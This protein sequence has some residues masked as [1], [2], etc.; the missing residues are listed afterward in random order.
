MTVMA[1]GDVFRALLWLAIVTGMAGRS[2]AQ[3]EDQPGDELLAE[4]NPPSVAE[5]IAQLQPI[6]TLDEFL[7]S[8]APS[9]LPTL[10]EELEELAQ[11]LKN[12]GNGLYR[13]GELEQARGVTQELLDLLVDE[14]GQQHWRSR[15]Q[16]ARLRV[17][18]DLAEATTEL[19]SEVLEA[20]RLFGSFDSL[21]Q[22]GEDHEALHAARHYLSAARTCFGADSPEV[23]EALN[24]LGVIITRA[25]RFAESDTCFR[26][27][28]AIWHAQLGGEHPNTATAVFNLGISQY[29]L[30]EWE[31]AGQLFLKAAAMRRSI[32]GDRHEAVWHALDQVADVLQG[33]GKYDLADPLAQQCVDRVRELLGEE[34]LEVAFRLQRLAGGKR[35]LGQFQVAK[36]LYREAISIAESHLDPEHPRL[37]EIR[38][39]FAVVLSDVGEYEEA[40]ELLYRSRS[41]WEKLHGRNHPQIA[42]SFQAEAVI[43]FST[44]DL[45]GAEALTRAAL[46]IRRK[47]GPD[48]HPFLLTILNNLANIM[49]ERGDLAEAEVLHREVLR[50]YQRKFGREHPNTVLGLSGLA[51]VLLTKG[52][53]S[54]A[55]L[56]LNEVVRLRRKLLGGDHPDVAI[57]LHNLSVLYYR[58]GNLQAALRCGE[59]ALELFRRHLGEGHPSTLSAVASISVIQAD[60][61]RPDQA[62]QMLTGLLEGNAAEQP[63]SNRAILHSNLGA[64]L[65][66]HLRPEEAE[67]QYRKAWHVL[68]DLDREASPAA[69]TILGNLASVRLTLEDWEGAIDYLERACSIAETLRTQVLADEL[70]QALYLQR[71]GHA[72]LSSELTHAL[73]RTGRYE[74]AV[75]AAEQG[76][77]R[78]LLDLVARSGEEAAEVTGRDDPNALELQA[79]LARRAAVRSRLV[80]AEVRFARTQ[81]PQ[82][83]ALS[84]QVVLM[85]A[86]RSQ[87]EGLRQEL[88]E[89]ET[90]VRI[91]QRESWP[92][93]DAVDATTI[94]KALK[95]AEGM[96]LYTWSE[97]AVSLLAIPASSEPIDGWIVAAGPRVDALAVEVNQ[98]LQNIR[99]RQD[100]GGR[101]LSRLTELYTQL[102]PEEA[103]GW[104]RDWSRVVVVPDGPLQFLPFQL[105]LSVQTGELALE[106]GP[107]VVLSGSGTLFVHARNTAVQRVADSTDT[108]LRGVI[109]A[110]P[111][112]EPASDSAQERSEGNA[113]AAGHLSALDLLRLYGGRLKPLP[114]SR[115]EAMAIAEMFGQRGWKAQV[116]LGQDASVPKLEAAADSATIVHLAAHGLVGTRTRPTDSSLALAQPV[117]PTVDDIGFLTLDRLLDRWNG[118]LQSC[119]LVVLSAC[120]TQRGVEVGDSLLALPWGFFH[121]GSPSV[122]ASLWQVDDD[123]TALLMRRFYQN[124]L[125]E[126][127]R[128]TLGDESFSGGQPMPKSTALREAQYWLSRRPAEENR[129]DLEGMKE[130]ASARGDQGLILVPTGE[131]NC[132]FSHPRYWA[133]FV[134]LG[135]PSACRLP[136]SN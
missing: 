74:E 116:F 123:A 104:L 77:A 79:A 12:E 47:T 49:C 100:L 61:G 13:N 90:E 52:D 37:A 43:Q 40:K 132:D 96:L 57:S 8:P 119:Q 70:Q 81:L 102:V 86:A 101:S 105:L 83:L 1:V 66:E 87:V 17:L 60:L 54:Q 27:A 34:H 133:A 35:L 68:E 88:K 31:Q 29:D 73:V 21:Y 41:V 36:K 120:D 6:P 111:Q 14:L 89:A 115:G 28:L 124:L 48:G 10:T 59:E 135:D 117:T 110:D 19:R 20:G 25:G 46:E 113:V 98:V 56:T 2:L 95:P 50:Q 93:A 55:L 134:L 82:D 114:S 78:V 84:T 18:D 92:H 15:D 22:A 136:S 97:R 38:H 42:N 51:A 118:K 32:F 33:L 94:Q 4:L 125:G 76:R 24:A 9:P 64:I 91:A 72:D 112:Y 5:L 63:W 3:S 26:Q 62:I 65:E 106:R 131:R 121:A 126:Y 71:L 39:G 99:S 11:A 44:G 23:A 80:A 53:A 107:D 69:A 58:S 109:L 16:Q 130:R 128:R 67:T 129:S 75:A 127:D 122:V 30:G 85:E 7:G 45:E 103:R 108:P